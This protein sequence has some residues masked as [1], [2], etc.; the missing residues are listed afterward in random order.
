MI[1]TVPATVVRVVDADSVRATLDLGF[2]V[3]FD[4]NC[5]LAHCDAP[6]LTTVAGRLARDYV[7]ALMPAGSPFTFVS[8]KLDKFGRPLGDIVLPDA[9]DLA[10]LLLEL[11]HAKPYEGGAR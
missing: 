11:G 5:R 3:L 1:W 8:H 7:A 10:T 9:R 4:A 2:R 6:E